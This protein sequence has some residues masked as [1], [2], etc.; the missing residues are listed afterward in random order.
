MIGLDGF[1]DRNIISHYNV[2][3][4]IMD[5]YFYHIVCKYYGI[6]IFSVYYWCK[7][8]F[9]C[10]FINIFI[11]CFSISWL[12]WYV[13]KYVFDILLTSACF[14]PIFFI[15]CVFQTL[16]YFGMCW[17][18]CIWYFIGVCL[19]SSIFPS[20]FLNLLVILYACWNMYLIFY[21]PLSEDQYFSFNVFQSLSYFGCVEI[22][23]KMYVFD[24][25]LMSAWGYY[26][27]L[28]SICWYK[29]SS[30][31]DLYSGEIKYFLII[32][33]FSCIALVI[34]NITCKLIFGYCPPFEKKFCIQAP[35]CVYQD[36]YG[37]K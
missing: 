19:R 14:F 32:W 13:L 8:I 16:D 5:I 28:L 25:V 21:W 31:S 15:Q 26:T 27:L 9:V 29:L 35:K 37:I 11:Q 34:Y 3:T 12:F 20:M 1:D 33:K 36:Y 17:N 6:Y 7:Y 4:Q 18:I 22:Y 24:I 2:Y 23:T 30:H 10:F